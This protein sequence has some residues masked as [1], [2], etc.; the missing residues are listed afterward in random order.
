MAAMQGK[1]SA[2]PAR[3]IARSRGHSISYLDAGAGQPLTLIPGYMQSA[4]DY[5]AAGYVDR[6]ATTH[7]VLVMDPLGH[8]ESDKP[9]DPAS[10]RSP[11]VAADVIAVLDAAGVERAVLWGYSR[12][13]W[14]AAMAAIEFPAR[15]AGLILGGTALTVTPST[16][17][18]A[19]VDSLSRGDWPEFFRLFPIPLSPQVMA[20]FEEGNDPQALAAERIG[21]LESAYEFDLG[22]VAA[23]SLVYCG[24]DDDPEDAV[25]TAQ[26]LGTEVR[27]VEGRDHFGTFEA[28]DQ[29]L[30]FAIPFLEAAIR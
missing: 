14:L 26:A 13:A 4:A 11:G 5:L 22:R 15:V 19:W 30:P 12:G 16:E 20:H 21:R 3:H 2:H 6:L 23:P 10:Y 9:S 7:R 24:G 8:G 28:L 18:P 1:L 17:I 29:V 25:P 27:V